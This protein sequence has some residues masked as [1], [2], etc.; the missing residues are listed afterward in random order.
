M[1]APSTDLKDRV[2][3]ALLTSSIPILRASSGA[4]FDGAIYDGPIAIKD[5]PSYSARLGAVQAAAHANP[6]DHRIISFKVQELQLSDHD[7][8]EIRISTP[9]DAAYDSVE[10]YILGYG[11]TSRP[12]DNRIF[13]HYTFQQDLDHVAVVPRGVARHFQTYNNEVVSRYNLHATQW[14]PSLAPFMLGFDVLA[15]GLSGLGGTAKD[16]SAVYH[17]P[18]TGVDFKGWKVHFVD[19][20]GGLLEGEGH[21]AVPQRASGTG[22]EHYFRYE[23]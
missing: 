7:S 13:Q 1:A 5:I 10:F 19:D 16:T 20:L 12:T 8:G 14:P 2:F 21:L 18:Q 4:P 22:G 11:S 3:D 9:K 23:E 17:S 6:K 15:G